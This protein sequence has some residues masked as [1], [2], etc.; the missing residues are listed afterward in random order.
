[1]ISLRTA[2]MLTA[3]A[4]LSACADAGLVTR[5]QPNDMGFV[6][7]RPAAATQPGAVA[8]SPSYH[9]NN[10]EVMVPDTLVVSE[11][12]SFF[13]NADIVWRGDPM[14]DRYVQVH[15]LI[16]AAVDKGVAGLDGERGVDVI[17]ELV[18]FHAVTEKT[19]FA[20]PPGTATHDVRMML[21]VVDSETGEEIE[22]AHPVGIDIEAHTS[23]QALADMAT[24]VTQKERISEALE[25][26]IRQ[27]L[28]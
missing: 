24:G 15:D 22:P 23:A 1:M 14:G 17:L 12:N 25:A 16:K 19:R 5:G 6:T 28:T 26:M 8:L 4:G 9:V 13:P 21:T 20:A 10:V 18:R 2:V 11:A 27:D 3:I 7:A